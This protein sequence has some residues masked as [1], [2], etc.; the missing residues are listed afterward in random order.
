[1]IVIATT[2]L[3]GS[4]LVAAVWTLIASVRAQFH[5]FAALGQPMT[6][7]PG[8]PPR[9]ARV[10]VRSVPARMPVRQPQRAAA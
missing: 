1:M 6:S 4:A 7:L 2:L 10:T 8:L 3:F 5:R 9:L